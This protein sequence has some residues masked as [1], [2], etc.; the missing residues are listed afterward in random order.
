MQLELSTASLNFGTTMASRPLSSTKGADKLKGKTAI[1]TGGDSGIGRAVAIM[2]A[3]EDCRGV[4]ISQRLAVTDATK[5]AIVSFTRSLAAQLMSKGIRVN[6]IAPG[7]VLTALQPASRSAENME[8]WGVGTPLHGRAGQP[9]E[10]AYVFIQRFKPHDWTSP[11]HQQWETHWC[12]LNTRVY[13]ITVC[14][15]T[16]KS[17]TKRNHYMMFMSS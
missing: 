2:F 12:F 3:H 6:A 13:S 11:A 4:T 14:Y 8:G 16:T 15:T 9:A 17:N 10:L 5:G 7:P 1:I